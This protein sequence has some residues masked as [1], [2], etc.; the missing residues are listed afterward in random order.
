MAH[1]DITHAHGLPA[2]DARRA[3]EDIA[4]KLAD[5]FDVSHRWQGQALLFE[6]PGVNGRITLAASEVQVQAEL[7]FLLSALK[8]PIEQEI[9]RYLDEKFGRD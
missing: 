7:G 1:I 4:G 2:A 5:R 8:G 9:R 6:R 3:V